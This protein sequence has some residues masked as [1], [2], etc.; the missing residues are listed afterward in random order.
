MK[1]IQVAAAVI[2]RQNSVLL[3][4]R[5]K[6]KHQGGLWEFP[7][8]KIE[9]GE[10]RLDALARELE[11]ELGIV[12]L[13]ATPLIQIEHDYP[14]KS[15]C[16]DVWEVTQFQGEPEG[17][18]GQTV[19]WVAQEA[20]TRYDFPAANV[21]IVTATQL[22]DCYAIS[23][24][25]DNVA[26]LLDW[27]DKVLASG[28]RLLLLRAPRLATDIYLD[29]AHR[30]LARCQQ[31]QARLMLHGDPA[32]LEKLPEAAGVHSPAHF[33]EKL[34]TRPLPRHQWWAVSTH[35]VEE[36]K[37]AC[38]L[39]A[40]FLTLSP[41]KKTASHPSQPSLGWGMFA[42]TVRLATCP[43]YALGGMTLQD[44]PQARANGA[45]GIAAIR[46]LSVLEL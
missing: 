42:E 32:L 14:D 22:P 15:V 30:I 46:G 37:K 1:R 19:Q 38:A 10:T 3:A 35:N 21:A 25:E 28:L 6:N 40:D 33:L 5:P 18:E 43:V 23:P 7:G 41:V 34:E 11:E 45:Q 4:R 12:P 24:D 36:L 9:P 17:R 39:Q 16:L 27:A 31:V 8:G 20:L 26:C 2:R 13:A 29:T 44:I